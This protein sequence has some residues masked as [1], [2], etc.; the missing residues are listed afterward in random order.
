[1]T[2][3]YAAQFRHHHPPTP[4]HTD[5]SISVHVQGGGSR[6]WVDVCVD[7]PAQDVARRMDALGPE[8]AREMFAGSRDRID[9]CIGEAKA[10]A[11]QAGAA[12]ACAQVGACATPSPRIDP[13]VPPRR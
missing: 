6:R 8:C 2:R 1:M 4:Q 7:A 12:Q 5:T 3:K 13:K 10:F 9:S 11:A